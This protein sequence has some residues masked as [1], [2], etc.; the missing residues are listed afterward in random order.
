[1]IPCRTQLFNLIGI[2]YPKVIVAKSDVRLEIT[3]DVDIDHGYEPILFV[4]KTARLR[5]TTLRL[6]MLMS[7]ISTVESLCLCNELIEL[8]YILNCPSV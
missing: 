1:M 5:V 7:T 4:G 6:S 3:C 8:N 2:I